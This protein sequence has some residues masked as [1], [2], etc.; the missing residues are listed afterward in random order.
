MDC[1]SKPSTVLTG[2]TSSV[3]TSTFSYN[4]HHIATC[5]SDET[6][7]VW[8][9]LPPQPDTRGCEV[10]LLTGHKGVVR[11]CDFSPNAALLASCSWDKSVHIYTSPDFEVGGWGYY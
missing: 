5:S 8:T 3:W 7:R 1:A 4:G 10:A 6:V 11:G 2:H 9:R